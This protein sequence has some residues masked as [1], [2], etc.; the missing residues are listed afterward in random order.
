MNA[1]A[2]L[3]VEDTEATQLTMPSSPFLMLCVVSVIGGGT[4]VTDIKQQRRRRWRKQ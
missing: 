4:I 3:D 2:I 1:L